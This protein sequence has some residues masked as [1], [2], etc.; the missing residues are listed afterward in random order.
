MFK[1]I[2]TPLAIT[3]A[4]IITAVLVATLAGGL[5]AMVPGMPDVKAGAQAKPAAVYQARPKADRLPIL[6]R[7][8]ACSANDQRACQFDMRRPANAMRTAGIV[9]AKS[10]GGQAAGCSVPFGLA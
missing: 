9:G 1:S 4:P 8:T 3:R 5:A 7:A 6:P 2:R 10:S